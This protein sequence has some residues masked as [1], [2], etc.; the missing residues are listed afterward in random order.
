MAAGCVV[1]VATGEEVAGEPAEVQRELTFIGGGSEVWQNISNYF[2]ENTGI[3]V[4]LQ[5]YPTGGGDAV[6]QKSIMLGEIEYDE[7][8]IQVRMD[9]TTAVY[10]QKEWFEDL[11]DLYSEEDIADIPS[12][13]RNFSDTYGWGRHPHNLA[14]IVFYRNTELVPEAPAMWEEMV[15]VAQ[16]LTNADEERWCWRCSGAGWAANVTAVMVRQAGGD[17]SIMDDEASRAAL[18]YRSSAG[19]ARRFGHIHRSLHRRLE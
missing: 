15:S 1:P 9:T 5:S 13:I 2:T 14:A 16:E 7:I 18:R 12:S 11:K 3:K 8:D 4:N 17:I 19:Q 10:L 6:T